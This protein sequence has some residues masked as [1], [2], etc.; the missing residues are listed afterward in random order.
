MESPYGPAGSGEAFNKLESSLETLQGRKF[1]ATFEYSTGQYRACVAV[2]NPDEPE[3]L[4]FQKW[5]VPGGL[6]AQEKLHAWT[7]HAD[8]IPDLFGKMSQEYK[9]RI[10]SSRPSIEF[11]KSQ[12]ELTLLLPIVQ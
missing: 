11:Y 3:R 10:D 1:Y 6:Y 2:K 8:E 9:G 7:E 5:N 12:K 4:G